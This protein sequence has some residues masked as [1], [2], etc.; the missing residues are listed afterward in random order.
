[1]SA[2]E[3]ASQRKYSRV[4]PS[5]KN[6]IILNNEV[7]LIEQTP[8]S[9]KPPVITANPVS[10]N[11][12]ATTKKSEMTMKDILARNTPD[13]PIRSGKFACW[14]RMSKIKKNNADHWN[15]T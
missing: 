7:A 4:A 5:K 10:N 1:M 9:M 8:K 3:L 15:Y 13:F 14:Q 2:D 12:G 11:E 6:Y